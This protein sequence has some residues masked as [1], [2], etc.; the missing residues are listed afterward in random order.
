MD[1]IKSPD[2]KF[3]KKLNKLKQKKYRDEYREYFVEGYKNVLDSISARPDIVQTI[4]FGESGYNEFGSAFEKFD[5]EKTVL[6]DALLSKISETS[7]AQGVMS[8]NRMTGEVFPR[9]NMCVLLDRVRDPGNVGTILRT[10]VACGYDVVLN[11]CADIYSPKVTRSAMSAIVKCNIGMN[12]DIA[13]LKAA[14]YKIFAADMHGQS[15]FGGKAIAD[16][17]CIVIG[18]EAD[19]VSDEILGAADRT[20][21]IPQENMESL[22]AAVAAGVMMFCMKYIGR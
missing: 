10:A 16:K 9:G 17:F 3:V 20:V 8:V 6:S 4:V 2:N 7:T 18:N 13:S 12:I 19:G 14:G 5:A 11:N 1:I 21:S 22:N 15:V